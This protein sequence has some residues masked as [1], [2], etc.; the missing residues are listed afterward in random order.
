MKTGKE[1]KRKTMV[2]AVLMATA[3]SLGI[4]NFKAM[5]WSSPAA[6]AI[7]LRAV[8]NTVVVSVDADSRLNLDDLERSRSISYQRGRNIFEM[9]Q[10]RS[11]RIE[12]EVRTSRQPIDPIPPQA[13]AVIPSIPL[14]FYGFTKRSGDRKVFLQQ[15]NNGH[16]FIANQGDVIDRRYRVVQVQPD[17]V[18]MEDLLTNHRQ[19]VP[20]TAH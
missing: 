18:L 15:Q 2:M 12:S 11:E 10:R 7:K 20:L 8:E 9:P 13:V 5:L 19:P 14:V 16:V 17:S 6:S 3:V 1:S 4:Y